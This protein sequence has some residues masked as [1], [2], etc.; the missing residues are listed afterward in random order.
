[1]GRIKT[2]LTKRIAKDLIEQYRDRFTND[3]SKNKEVLK[4]MVT[5]ESKRMRN[6]VVGYITRLMHVKK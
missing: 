2:H 3:F 6:I 4:T 1:M 5:F